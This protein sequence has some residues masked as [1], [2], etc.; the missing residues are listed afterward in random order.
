MVQASRL[1]QVWSHTCIHL[2]THMLS[3]SIS[4]SS[5]NIIDTV[6]LFNNQN[7][8][9][10]T[11]L[12]IFWGRIHTIRLQKG[13]LGSCTFF[14][15]LQS[16]SLT[17][18]VHIQGT[19]SLMSGKLPFKTPTHSPWVCMRGFANRLKHQ[20]DRIMTSIMITL[21]DQSCI[22]FIIILRVMRCSNCLTMLHI[23]NQQYFVSGLKI[24]HSF[25]EIR[26]LLHFKNLDSKSLNLYHH[27]WPIIHCVWIFFYSSS[28][29]H[30]C[31]I[32]VSN[33]NCLRHMKI[34][35]F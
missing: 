7:Q 3:S 33:T 31:W 29:A 12:L 18:D 1:T 10:L 4:V 16:P 17:Q 35:R 22:K 19:V 11:S 21:P 32:N 6:H 20:D 13:H 25:I 23:S 8:Y 27:H 30:S 9:V 15:L 26:L 34:L 2:V 28:T 24:A 5:Y 14:L